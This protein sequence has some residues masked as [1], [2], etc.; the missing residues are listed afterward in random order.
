LTHDVG[1]VG[2]AWAVV[3]HDDV[4]AVVGE[5]VG[6]ELADVRGAAGDNGDLSAEVACHVGFPSS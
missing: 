3:V 1:L 4:G 5:R 2:A 6:E